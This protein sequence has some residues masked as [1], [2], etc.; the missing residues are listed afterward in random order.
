MG[1]V[2]PTA[3]SVVLEG[4]D[5]SAMSPKQVR[6]ARRRMQMV[7]QDPTASL[8]SRM[9]VGQLVAEPL[10]VHDIGSPDDRR[11]RV[12]ELLVDV[13]LG[14]DAIDRFPHQFSGGQ[15]QRIAIARALAAAPDLLVCDEPIAALDVSVRAQVINLLVHLQREHG[16]SYLFI[17]HDL[18]AVR[19]V[20][21]R[22]AVMYLGKVMELVD[23]ETLYARP[24]HPYTDALLSAVPVPNPDVEQTRERIILTGDVPSPLNPPSGCVFRTRCPQAVDECATSVPELRD[25]GQP[26]APHWV[27]CHLVGRHG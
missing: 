26:G 22:V 15:R 8:N 16:L 18:A 1:L 12:L 25:L 6:H 10:I 24:L 5:L 11:R 7:F 27:A 21:H 19:H 20:A 13:G 14:E 3:G 9:S 4:T 2:P 23:G 17:S